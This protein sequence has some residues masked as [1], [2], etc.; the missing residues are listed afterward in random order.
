MIKFYVLQSQPPPPFRFTDMADGHKRRD[1]GKNRS[2]S[3]KQCLDTF[4]IA[5]LFNMNVS[6]KFTLPISGVEKASQSNS[7]EQMQFLYQLRIISI[8]ITT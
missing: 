4:R 8:A 2:L 1:V 6:M 3:T 5:I 7:K